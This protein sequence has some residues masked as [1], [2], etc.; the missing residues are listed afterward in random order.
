MPLWK[1]RTFE[2]AERH[3]DHLPWTAESSLGS[4]LALLA[5][6]EG[7]RRGVR[8]TQR[9]LTRYRTVAEAEADRQRFALEALR[10]SIEDPA[11]ATATMASGVPWVRRCDGFAEE[12]EA[13]RAFWAS[14]SPAQRVAAVEDLRRQWLKMRG[15]RDEGLRRVVRV[16][17]PPRR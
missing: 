14:L 11:A 13:D 16:L 10:R 4:A 7:V 2:E 1:F 12:A 9:G 5:L 3:L 6:A 17:E 15:T 8:T